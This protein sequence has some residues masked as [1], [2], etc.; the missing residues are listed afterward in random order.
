MAAIGLLIEAAW[1]RV[2]GVTGPPP[3]FVT[4]NPWAQSILPSR[5]TATLTPGTLRAFIRSASEARDGWPSIVTAGSR[6][7][8]TASMR[9]STVGDAAQAG[10]ESAQAAIRSGVDQVR[11]RRFPLV[12]KAVRGRQSASVN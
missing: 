8:V 4:P 10:P 6:P 3:T 9:C 7:P 1:K 12:W 2:S 11:M 5:I